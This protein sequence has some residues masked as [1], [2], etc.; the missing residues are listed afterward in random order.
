[1]FLTNCILMLLFEIE[2]A[3]CIKMCLALNNLQRLIYLKT[4]LFNQPTNQPTK[5]VLI[6]ITLECINF[7]NIE[8]INPT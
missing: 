4:P 1:M 7:E 8:I 3:I 5:N 2:L 6:E